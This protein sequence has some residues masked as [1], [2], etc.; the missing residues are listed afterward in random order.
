MAG[1][2]G[3]GGSSAA[4]RQ[5]TASSNSTAPAQADPF[6]RALEPIKP[7][8]YSG[9]R[10]VVFVV[11]GITQLEVA[12]L[13]RMSRETGREIVYGG[14]SLL[15]FRDL[16]DQLY[17][18]DPEVEDLG[19]GTGGASSASGRNISGGGGAFPAVDDF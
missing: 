6:T 13:E 4:A 7:R 19:G 10:I 14:T 9:G 11:G 12:A 3:A 18:V 8:L 5:G 15:T 2:T 17:H 1:G 16:L